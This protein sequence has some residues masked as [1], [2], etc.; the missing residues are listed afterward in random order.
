MKASATPS[1]K[2]RF[3][4]P[5]IRLLEK[6][7][8]G[9][10]R[11]LIANPPFIIFLY[12]IIPHNRKKDKFHKK[13]PLLLRKG[14]LSLFAFWVQIRIEVVEVSSGVPSTLYIHIQLFDMEIEVREIIV[15]I[16]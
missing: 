14:L 5:R 7:L 13:K 9:I 2:F 8:S 1:K 12:I 4:K 6:T 11:P 15:I 10:K 16:I 3:R